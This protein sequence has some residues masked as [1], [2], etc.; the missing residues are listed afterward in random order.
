M[1]VVAAVL[2]HPPAIAQPDPEVARQ[3]AERVGA[4]AGP[5]HLLVAGVVAEEAEL[6]E[7]HAEE[8]RRQQLPPGG[9][10]EH[11]GDPAGQAEGDRDGDL[12][13]V[14]A[15]APAQQP[16]RLDPPRQLGVVA[17]L[18]TRRRWCHGGA[19]ITGNVGGHEYA[20]FPAIL[21]RAAE[22]R[23]GRLSVSIAD[24]PREA[25]PN[26]PPRRDGGRQARS[27]ATPHAVPS[28]GRRPTM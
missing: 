18:L 26:D 12:E 3:Q 14:V 16:R 8:H 13:R 24:Y 2:V 17:A 7:H 21:K 19:E 22:V 20:A 9:S 6:G 15:R 1:G 5:E 23:G 10:D 4:P 25:R 27:R 28:M 11:E